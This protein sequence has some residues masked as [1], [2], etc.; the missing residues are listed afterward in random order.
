MKDERIKKIVQQ[1]R[2]IRDFSDDEGSVLQFA[3]EV[4]RE[5]EAEVDEKIRI[6]KCIEDAEDAAA[7][8]EAWDDQRMDQWYIKGSY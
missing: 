2:L 7:F 4:L 3:A 8:K 1:M 5:L 6:R